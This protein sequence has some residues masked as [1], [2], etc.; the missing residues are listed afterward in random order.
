MK[1][2]SGHNNLLSIRINDELLE[3]PR[4]IGLA[5]DGIESFLPD[6]IDQHQFGRLVIGAGLGD[7]ILLDHG[8]ADIV[9]A[10]V[11]SAPAVRQPNS[12]PRNLNVRNIVEIES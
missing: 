5:F 10:E 12:Q 1:I 2:L 9:G 3:N 7:D 6:D 8:R 4:V 11:E